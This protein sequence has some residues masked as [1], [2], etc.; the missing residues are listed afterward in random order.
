MSA[1]TLYTVKDLELQTRHT[2]QAHEL[3]DAVNAGLQSMSL[4]P[5]AYVGEL[6]APEGQSTAGGVQSLQHL[7][8]VPRT[9]GFPTLVVGMA[10]H[11]TGAADVRSFAYVDAV[12]QAR[13]GTTVPL[14]RAAYD[15]FLSAATSLLE[16][17]QLKV[18]VVD[19][20]RA[21]LDAAAARMAQ[22][23][24]AVDDDGSATRAMTGLSPKVLGGL[25]AGALVVGALVVALRAC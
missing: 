18:A 12:Y 25:F 14:D 17:V 11:V 13:F 9:P 19:A 6:T 4:A 2:V 21:D 7:R 5:G 20:P 16:V 23:A 15:E 3:A 8:L 10:N 1:R 22:E 24:R